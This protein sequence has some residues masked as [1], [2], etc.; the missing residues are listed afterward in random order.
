[1]KKIGLPLLLILIGIVAIL[2]GLFSP[3]EKGDVEVEIVKRKNIMPSAHN[4]YSGENVL[5]GKYY[6]FKA[7]ITNKTGKKLEDVTVS[8]EIPGMIRWEKLDLIGEMLPGQVVSVA[9]YPKFDAKI[10]KKTTKSI[11]RANI[12]ITWEGSG[13]DDEIEESFDFVMA[14]RNDFFYTSIPDE[15][16]VGWPDV[17]ADADLLACMVTPNDPIVKYYTQNI[18]Q[19]VLKGEQATVVKTPKEALRFLLGIYQAT[20]QSKMVYSGSGGTPVSTA[21]GFIDFSQNIRL[22][23]E[24][25][26]GNTGLCIELSLLYASVL[27]NAGLDPIIYLVPQHAYPGFKLNGQYYAIEATTIAGEGLGGVG[28]AQQALEKGTKGLQQ[29]ISK[30][31]MGD[32][33]YQIIDIHK[34]H[35]QGVTPM[36]LEDDSFLRKKV[37]DITLSWSEN[38]QT[39][40]RKNTRK[41]Q[42]RAVAQSQSSSRSVSRSRQFSFPGNFQTYRNP[43]PLVTTLSYQSVS[44]NGQV[45]ISVFDVPTTNKQEA[46]RVIQQELY[47]AGQSIEY[48][49][50]GRTIRG[51]TYASGTTFVWKGK[52]INKGNRLQFIAVGALNHN[53]NYNSSLINNIYNTIP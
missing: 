43:S 19:K 24:V 4:V 15:E 22:P 50:N 3:T 46:M 17:Y 26:T 47:N 34:L 29:F 32:P 31:R 38:K 28:T 20:I 9:C 10:T 35:N 1:M 21:N 45:S 14:S 51:N 41:R 42:Q 53:Y 33:R 12:K 49:I 25:I 7:K 27:S 39:T 13:K 18:Q 2:F 5:N 11:E 48:Q 23:R 40:P 30:A 52:L 37:D 16:I 36:N 8:Y 44:P 6:L